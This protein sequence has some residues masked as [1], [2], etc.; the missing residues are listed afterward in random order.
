MTTYR[1]KLIEVGLPLVAINAESAREK[2]IRHGHPSTLH[3]WWARRPLAACRA[4]LFASLVDDPDSDP[5]YWKPNGTVDEDRAGIKRV[6]LFNLIEEL[7]MWEN[8]NNSDVIRTARAEIARCVA[9][10]LIET[11]ALKKDAAIGPNTSAYDLVKR[12]HCR[13][14]SLGLD[15]KIG[16]VRFSF[17]VSRLPPAEVVNAFLAEYAPPVLDPFAGGGSIPLEAQ[18]LGLRAYASD[19]NPISVLI[20]KALIEIP[21]KFADRPPVNPESRGEWPAT[22]GKGKKQK[23]LIE[24]EWHGA[25]G[26][27]EDVRY[28]GQWMR[29]EAEKR[30]GHLYPKVAVT[31]EMAQDRPDLQPYVGQQLTVIAWLWARTVASPNPA[32]GGAHVPLVSSF[33]VSTKKGRKAWIEPI[34]DKLENTYRFEIRVGSPSSLEQNKHIDAGTKLGRGCHF[35]CILSDQPINDSHVK[36]EGMAD[37][38]GVRLMAIVAEGSRERI[39]L[40]P[41]AEHERIALHAA[42]TGI[43][44]IRTSIAEDRRAIW[45]L[46]YG[47]NRFD[48]LFTS[49]Q[50]VAL[51]TFS[52]L[53]QEV[54]ERVMHDSND[55]RNRNDYADALATYLAFSISKLSDRSSNLCSWFT[56]RDSTR[57]TFARQGLPMVWDF[58]ELNT[59]NK[60]TGTFEG[61]NSWT[62]EVVES[63]STNQAGVVAQLDATQATATTFAAPVISTDPPY[64]DNIGYADLSDFFY[65]WLRRALGAIYPSLFAT[66]LTPKSQELI[67]SPYRHGGSKAK[68]QEFFETGLGTAFSRARERHDLDIPM[69][70]FYA[71][72]Q[73]ESTGSGD[74]DDATFASASTGWETMLTG[75]VSAGFSVQGTWPMRTELGNRM[76]GMGTNALASSIVLACR[77]RPTNAPLASRK[78]FI[79]ALRRELPDALRNLQRGNIA[80]VD[81][82][83]AAI[84]PGMG[85][86]TR[87]SK[88]VESDGRPMTVRTALGIINQVL[89]EVLAEQEGDFEPDTRWALAW[90]EQFG[91]SEGPYGV[92]EILSKAKDTAING[93]VEAGV[94]KAGK[95][96]V[97]LL[98]R[99]ELPDGWNPATDKRLTVWET[100]QHLIRTL[101]IKGEAEA[102]ALL[103]KLGGIGEI[104]RELA[105]RLYSIC[106]RKKW[107]QDAL[108]YNSLVIAWPELSKLALSQRNKQPTIQQDLF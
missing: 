62:A 82:A 10:R 83:Q 90:F 74:G 70:V 85:V 37:R 47:L 22:K 20:N 95:G 99:A 44:A 3:L 39:Y 58:A 81:L 61:A 66:L 23:S 84:G 6:D 18:R 69:T 21:P 97:Q 13:P 49:R 75:L 1:K 19:L 31:A 34:V 79:T 65:V 57:S 92:A 93:L 41:N 7:V 108:A 103:N 29:D 52:D 94:V 88:V 25:A 107:A 14:I 96:K 46:L 64:Y 5:M 77:P 27:A 30:I 40:S 17:D 28:Y 54:H 42:P 86:F 32:C 24:K 55:S 106:E 105:Y 87:Y 26:L 56:E 9:S 63:L 71:F 8:S 45:C 89:D 59:L 2:S 68:A 98:A 102:A 15:T 51:E 67:A 60:G 16:R 53:V 48:K 12:G 76:V 78:E 50:L 91:T 35:R 73:T 33:W 72:K 36:T 38:M 80:P 4:V 43:D 100:T 101:E 104:A 11:G